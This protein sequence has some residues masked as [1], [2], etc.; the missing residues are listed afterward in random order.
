VQPQALQP[1]AVLKV[2]FDSLIAKQ[3]AGTP[4]TPAQ[5]AGSIDTSQLLQ[6]VVA[7]LAANQPAVPQPTLAL[8]AAPA[9]STPADTVPTLSPIDSWLGGQALAGK[10][11]ALAVVAYAVL[12]ILQA[13]DVAGTATGPAATTTGQILTTLIAAF[14]GLGGLSKIDRIVQILGAAAARRAAAPK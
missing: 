6:T 11:T 14:G 2:L 3:A 13:V 10:K 1:Q 5:P 7:A 4:A 9:T 12:S 8:P